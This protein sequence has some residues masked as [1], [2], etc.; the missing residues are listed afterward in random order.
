VRQKLEAI[1]GESWATDDLTPRF[2]LFNPRAA[3]DHAVREM[4]DEEF[5]R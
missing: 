4:R 5:S 1:T 3:A 2:A